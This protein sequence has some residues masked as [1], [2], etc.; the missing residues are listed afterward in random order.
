MVVITYRNLCV[1]VLVQSSLATAWT[2][3]VVAASRKIE[4]ARMRITQP[5]RRALA[6]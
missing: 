5:G 1:R 3:R 6:K 4:A 2:E